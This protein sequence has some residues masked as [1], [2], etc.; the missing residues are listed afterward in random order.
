MSR[1]YLKPNPTLKDF[2]KYIEKM[3]RERGF[4]T[5]TAKDLILLLIEEVGEL[6]RAIRKKAGIKIDP[7]SA[8][9]YEIEEELADCFIYLLDLSNQLDVDLEKAFRKKEEINKKRY[10]KRFK[11]TIK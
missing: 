4:E 3:V 8:P 11:K 9:L 5:E 7:K 2:Q 1:L 10:W 6:A